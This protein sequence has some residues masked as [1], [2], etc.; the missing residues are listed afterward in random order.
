[1]NNFQ[2][3]IIKVGLLLAAFAIGATLLVA[4]TERQTRDQITENQRQALLDG[5]HDL[6]PDE[7]YDNAILQ[8]TILIPAT[9]QLGL[10]QPQKIYRA[11]R[12]GVPVAIIMPVVAPDGYSGRIRLLVGIYHDGTLAGVRVLEHRETPG[13]GDKI[14]AKRSDWITEFSGKSLD[15]PEPRDW[16][17]KKD[18]GAFD[19]FT[20][21]TI[22]P[23]A[24]INAVRGA[25]EYF[26]INR[27]ALF[28]R[29]NV[30]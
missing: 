3:H 25:L 5:I 7:E 12:D 13:L 26:E 6:L 9:D 29:Q 15:N 18:G 10:K 16:R 11:R 4:I 28:A 23:R 20:G 14:E 8:D 2:S 27:N 17:V 1:M 24:V 22:T 21:A 19:Q 30:E